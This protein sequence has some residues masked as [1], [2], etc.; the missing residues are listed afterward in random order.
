[1]LQDTVA[2]VLVCLLLKFSCLDDGL[3]TYSGNLLAE[4]RLS[5]PLHFGGCTGCFWITH[6]PVEHVG[7]ENA[8]LLQLAEFDVN[9][10]AFFARGASP[11]LGFQKWD[12]SRFRCYLLQER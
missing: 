6:H 2:K 9:K 11:N 1:M 3:L 12:G 5:F 7:H 8:M 4:L 10:E